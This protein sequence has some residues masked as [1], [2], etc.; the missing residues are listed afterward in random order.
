MPKG[1]FPI[2]NGH[3]FA[4]FHQ[5][6]AIKKGVPTYGGHDYHHLAQAKYAQDLDNFFSILLVS[7]CL[8]RD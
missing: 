6:S 2:G 1:G 8:L 5:T 4:R 7:R 3:Q